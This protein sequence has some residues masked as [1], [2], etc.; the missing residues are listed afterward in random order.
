[1]DEEIDNNDAVAGDLEDDEGNLDS[2]LDNLLDVEEEIDE[3]E[4]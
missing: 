2:L 3:E 4:E 1:L